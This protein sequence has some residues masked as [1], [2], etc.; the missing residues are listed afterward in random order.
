MNLLEGGREVNLLEG[1]RGVNI[2]EAHGESGCYKQANHMIY[3][4]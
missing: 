1:G 4:L 3:D 2:L